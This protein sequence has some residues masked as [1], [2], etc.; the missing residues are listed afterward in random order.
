LVGT[1]I[2]WLMPT[3]KVL[4]CSMAPNGQ[5]AE[6]MGVIIC[7][8]SALAWIPPLLFGVINEAGWSL[9]W[10]VASQDLLLVLALVVSSGIGDFED[11][12]QQA[13]TTY[14]TQYQVWDRVE[15][16]TTQI[17]TSR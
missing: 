3:E 10:A 8:H 1:S 7:V 2:G 16:V 6:I 13:R 11:A 5:E 12:V 9:Q 4:F 15:P 14:K 17:Y